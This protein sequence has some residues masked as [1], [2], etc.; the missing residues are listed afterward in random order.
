MRY[1]NIRSA[2]AEEGV[3]RLILLDSSLLE[4]TEGLTGSEF[5]S[6]LLGRIFDLLRSRAAEGLS[7]Q[8]PALAGALEPEEM[9]HLAWVASP[10]GKSGQQPQSPWPT[11]SPSS[12][13]RGCAAAG[14]MRKLC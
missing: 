12:G 2:R 3:L 4:E 7:T 5:S 1:D 11:T 13:R 14:Q 8:L 6:P 10:A 9:A